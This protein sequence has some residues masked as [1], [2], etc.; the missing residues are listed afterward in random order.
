M[1]KIKLIAAVDSNWGIGFENKLLFHLKK[2]MEFF[3]EKTVGNIVVMGRKTLQS[4]PDGK[5][6]PERI[7][8]VLTKRNAEE[9]RRKYSGQ[10]M[11]PF[12]VQ[13][14]EELNERLSALEGEVFV[15]GGGEVYR[16]FL[17]DASDAYITRVECRKLA[18]TYFPDLDQNVEWEVCSVSERFEEKGIAFRFWHYR[19]RETDCE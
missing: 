14:R 13:S 18:D 4:F 17:P 6:L 1:R 12:I 19:R 15:I 11:S 3:R 5:P 9:L 8:L 16:E 7:N 10:S 2:D